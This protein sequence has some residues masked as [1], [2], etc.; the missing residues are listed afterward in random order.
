MAQV[1]TTYL[2][3]LYA[4]LGEVQAKLDATAAARTGLKVLRKL[5][6]KRAPRLYTLVL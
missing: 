3:A 4:N 1:L 6:I 2:L 5:K